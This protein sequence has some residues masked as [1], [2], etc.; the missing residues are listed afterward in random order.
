MW[1]YNYRNRQKG[2]VPGNLTCFIWDRR[3]R[4]TLH[5]IERHY[6]TNMHSPHMNH[7]KKVTTHERF[8][9]R[10]IMKS[11]MCFC[12]PSERTYARVRYKCTSC[13]RKNTHFPH[14]YENFTNQGYL[15]SAIR[16]IKKSPAIIIAC[17]RLQSQ[18]A[19]AAA[20]ATRYPARSCTHHAFEKGATMSKA[21]AATPDS[22]RCA[23]WD[24]MGF[25]SLLH[26][27]WRQHTRACQS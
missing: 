4:P 26:N 5:P 1:W 14:S 3:S 16:S 17:E 22:F 13:L 8:A 9:S 27:V 21:L 18:R 19:Q 20:A 25:G 15:T 12:S 10:N 7:N 6:N 24:T 2:G 23:L 11:S